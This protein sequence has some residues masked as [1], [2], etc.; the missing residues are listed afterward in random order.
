MGEILTQPQGSLI[1]LLQIVTLRCQQKE[2][3][4]KGGQRQVHDACIVC[5][6]VGKN[7]HLGTK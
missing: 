2:V 3:E 7:A 1:I 5:T 6:A 4:H